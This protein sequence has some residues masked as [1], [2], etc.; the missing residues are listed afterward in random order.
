[1]VI[2]TVDAA[3]RRDRHRARDRHAGLGLR[4]GGRRP[5]RGGQGRG[6]R[7]ARRS[8]GRGRDRLRDAAPARA[9]RRS[10]G[11]STSARGAARRSSRSSWRSERDAADP[12]LVD[13]LGGR[14]RARH[15]RRVPAWAARSRSSMA[16]AGATVWINDLHL[17]RAET[18]VGEIE[19]EGGAARAGRRPTCAISTSVRDDA[20]QTGPVDILV[21][22][23]G[24]GRAGVRA[25]ALRRDQAVRR[26][27]SPTEWEP[28]IAAEPRRGAAR[29]PRVPAGDDRARWGRIL[30]IVSDAGRKGERNQVGLRRGQGRGDGLLAGARGRGR[31]QRA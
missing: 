26:V 17:E 27:S 16:H 12:R 4:G 1:M 25:T 23:A 13:L 14:T 28:V 10:A 18:V 21:N 31:A 2:V 8:R 6:A 7:V 19:A 5:H 3:H 11:S 24:T 22:N 15:R 30:T 9:A 29:D 20:R